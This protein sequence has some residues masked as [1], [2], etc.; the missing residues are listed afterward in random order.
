MT[1]KDLIEL[2]SIKDNYREFRDFINT[3]N[4]LS[5]PEFD[6]FVINKISLFLLHNDFS[7]ES[8]EEMIEKIE[9]VL[10]S[11]KR[12]F[13]RPIIH[14]KDNDEVLPVEAVKLINN[15]SINHIAMHTEFWD[16]IEDGSIKPK[17]LMTR[18]YEDN[19]SIYE[20]QLFAK[21]IDTILSYLKINMR[22]LR[23]MI[24]SSKILE[25]N[26]LERTNHANYFLAL[27][28]L[29]TGYIRDF[30]KNYETIKKDYNKLKFLYESISTRLSA[31]VYRLNKN[32]PKNLSIHNSN[33][34]HMQRDYHRVYLTLK[35]L[36]KLKGEI[37]AIN[38]IDLKKLKENYFYYLEI[39]SIFS[40]INFNF[41]INNKSKIDF[42][43][44]DLNFNL[45]NYS[46]NL[47]KL[48]D[49]LLFEI[50][51]DITYTILLTIGKQ[52]DTSYDETISAFTLE[53]DSSL[54]LSIDDIDSFRRIQQFILRGMINS[55]VNFNTCMYC[56]EKFEKKNESYICSYC[57]TKI[58]KHLCPNFNKFY[59]TSDIDSYKAKKFND[60]KTYHFR[61][62]TKYNLKG[63]F[64]CPYC[65][66]VHKGLI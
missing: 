15:Q 22:Y 23:N 24:F 10:P 60:D 31:R 66:N 21:T 55:T 7:F 65:N 26:L 36:K 32:Y 42:N 33:I 59:Y 63:E 41:E 18:V 13:V 25:M 54:L 61:N 8:L 4:N 35:N 1:N 30:S 53:D 6:Y 56:G 47:K 45:Y 11:I 57:R 2:N 58:T 50:K 5:I 16:N 51:N 39:L 49:K 52:K 19:F 46:L 14:L 12:I 3:Y 20:N 43:N 44:L 29:Q 34:L 38:E 62:I 17:K 48:D 27:A 40:I 9:Y 64:I 37:E 28:K